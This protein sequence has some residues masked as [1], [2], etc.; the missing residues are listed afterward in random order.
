[1]F[2]L[3]VP[4]VLVA[5]RTTNYIPC[6]RVDVITEIHFL[7]TLIPVQLNL[8]YLTR[9]CR[10]L[11][12]S[13]LN[14]RAC[15]LYSTVDE[16]SDVLKSQEKKIWQFSFF[17]FSPPSYPSCAPIMYFAGRKHLKN[18]KK[19]IKSMEFPFN[20]FFLPTWTCK[21]I[22]FFIF[23]LPTSQKI[24]CRDPSTLEYKAHALISEKINVFSS[25]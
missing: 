20:F 18:T 13:K 24:P 11:V 8:K 12:V 2:L 17:L 25:C 5:A 6:S 22:I 21:H 1:M 9:F 15:A 3:G 14:L 16:S 10:F 4:C 19:L 7:L 23:F